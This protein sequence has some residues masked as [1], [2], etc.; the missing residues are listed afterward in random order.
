MNFRV[1]AAI[2]AIGLIGCQTYDF[3]PVRPLAVAQTVKPVNIVSK[4]AK[5]NLFLVVDKSGSMNFSADTSA[6]CAG[7]T[8]C[9]AGC[10]TRISELKASM[11]D[12][13]RNAGNIGHMG[14]LPFPSTSDTM[15]GTEC[16]GGTL[17]DIDTKGEPLDVGGPDDD[18]T[19]SAHALKINKAI[20]ML[21]PKGGTPTGLTL[22]VLKDYDPLLNKS[23]SNYV[24]LLTDGQPNCNPA[25]NPNA[26]TCTASVPAGQ[27][28]SVSGL[29]QCLDRDGTVMD[30]A[31]LYSSGIKTIVIGF[32]AELATGTGDA[33][34]TLSAMGAAGGFRRPCSMDSMC[35]T[36]DTCSV[37]STDPCGRPSKV[38]A[39]TFFTAQNA[40]ELTSALTEISNS[41]RCSDPCTQ[42]LSA[43]PTNDEEALV[44]VIID[45]KNVQPGA[46]TWKYDPM[47][48]SVVFPMGT[49][50][51]T[52]M[53]NATSATPVKL[54]IRVVE[55][56]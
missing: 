56:L 40:T 2:A 26:C 30:V 21:N 17:A 36:G 47:G 8:S 53:L 32:G 12:F 50:I 13:L 46:Q 45:G 33:V 5:P 4:E 9:P 18:A 10:K 27:P 48:P 23:R 24:L 38:C 15:S 22:R 29:N 11:D 34:T 39:R 37:N 41:I 20:S 19:L 54:E 44:S 14:M 52:S 51:C 55:S 6:A 7:C 16:N 31:T 42:I 49:P 28:C 3:E 25:N 35:G 43:R 1:L